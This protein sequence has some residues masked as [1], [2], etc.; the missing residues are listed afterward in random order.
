ML[1]DAQ[2]TVRALMHASRLGVDSHGIRLTRYY[3]D[4]LTKG[5]VNK[6][7]SR[8]FEQTAPST[9]RLN[10]DFGLA[11]SSSYQAMREAINLARVTGIGAVT[12]HHS[13]HFGAAGAYALE[14]A[15]LG[16]VGLVFSNS[17]PAVALS[18]GSQPFHGTNPLAMAA[19]VQNAKPWLLDMSTSSIPFNRVK[20]NRSLDLP[21]PAEVALDSE[22]QPTQ[23][24]LAAR[25]LQPLG[26]LNYGYKGAALAGMV[27]ILA[28]ILAGADPDP[29]MASTDQAQK[30]EKRQNVGHMMIALNPAHFVGQKN[31]ESGLAVYLELLRA[32]PTTSADKTLLAPGDKEWAEYEHRKKFGIPVDRDTELFLEIKY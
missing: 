5:G 7:P 24:A 26:G 14:A 29:L 30:G 11:H 13:T 15:E 1:N 17:D 8:L 23:N 4:M 32:S 19:P 28:G 3:C 9:G 21:L 22:G 25:F 2:D 20:L 27:T 10:A 18:G 16:F 12:V 6:S 31:F